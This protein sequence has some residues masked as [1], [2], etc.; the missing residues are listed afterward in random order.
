VRQV[1]GNVL[2]HLLQIEAHQAGEGNKRLERVVLAGGGGGVAGEVEMGDLKSRRV[3]VS[4]HGVAGEVEIGDLKS[5]RVEVS[6][7]G[8]AGEVKMGD[9]K[10]RRVEVST[11]AGLGAG[12]WAGCHH[13]F[14]CLP[15]VERFSLWTHHAV[16]HV[17]CFSL[18]LMRALYASVCAWVGIGLKCL[19]VRQHTPQCC[20][21]MRCTPNR[22]TPSTDTKS[23]QPMR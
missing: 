11:H 4:A 21:P 2:V 17:E 18:L 16:L 20:T 6:A 7:H 15:Q 12:C 8:V 10:S 3:E 5:R 22:S 23:L 19:A 9:L 13:K 1:A 14:V